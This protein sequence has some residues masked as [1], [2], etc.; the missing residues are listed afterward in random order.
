MIARLFIIHQRVL[1]MLCAFKHVEAQA[2]QEISFIKKLLGIY[3][4]SL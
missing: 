1:K 3:E 2:L 4:L